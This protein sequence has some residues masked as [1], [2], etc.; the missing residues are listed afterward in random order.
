MRG[1]FFEYTPQFL[2]LF[3]GNYRPRLSGVSD[4]MRRRLHLLPFR[5][6]PAKVD[7]YLID[8]FRAEFPVIMAMAFEGCLNYQRMCLAPPRILTDATEEYLFL[9]I[10]CWIVGGTL[11]SVECGALCGLTRSA[12]KTLRGL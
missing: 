2:L 7:R 1:D 3:H 6:K 10:K 12:P 11:R 4:A 9:R 5:F 8:K